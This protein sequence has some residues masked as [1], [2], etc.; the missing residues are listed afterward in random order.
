[1]W[2]VATTYNLFY[3]HLKWKMQNPKVAEFGHSHVIQQ[4]GWVHAWM[5]AS[6][7]VVTMYC[8]LTNLDDEVTMMMTTCMYTLFN[9]ILYRDVVFSSPLVVFRFKYELSYVQWML[10]TV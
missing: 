6:Y 2:H 8:A 7:K 5:L 1:M 10:L 3:W 4:R 9:F